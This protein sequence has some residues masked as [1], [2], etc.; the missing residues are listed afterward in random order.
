MLKPFRCTAPSLLLVAA[1]ALVACG[2][3]GTAETALATGEDANCQYATTAEVLAIVG[4]AIRP[5]D[6]L[7]FDPTPGCDWDE[8]DGYGLVSIMVVDAEHY[9]EPY[10]APDFMSVSGLG[11]QAFAVPEWNAWKAGARL[12]EL[13]VFV[14]VDGPGESAET[15]LALLRHV[16]D[17][18]AGVSP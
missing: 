1:L 18:L 3:H 10:G 8:V 17:G 9:S 13:A 16:V 2:P 6:A 4:F 15:A 12:P 5:S 7:P 11:E 14:L